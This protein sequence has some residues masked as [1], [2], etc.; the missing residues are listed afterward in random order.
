M[1]YMQ[2]G[3]HRLRGVRLLN[4]KMGVAGAAKTGI[5]LIDATGYKPRLKY[6]L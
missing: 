3:G 2:P 4:E 5:A 1:I 6:Y